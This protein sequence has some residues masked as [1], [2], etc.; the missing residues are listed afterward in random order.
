MLKIRGGIRVRLTLAITV[1]SLVLM[2]IVGLAIERT[3]GEKIFQDSRNQA[4]ALLESLS[5]PCAMEKATNSLERLD[6]SLAE[7]VRVGGGKLPILE[8][9]F[10]DHSGNL[11][12][13]SSQRHGLSVSPGLQVLQRAFIDSSIRSTRPTWTRFSG[14]DDLAV[15]QVSMPAVS[16]LRWGTLVAAFHL[17][18]VMEELRWTRLILGGTAIGLALMLVILLHLTLSWMV[19]SPIRNL[20]DAVENIQQGFLGARAAVHSA[21]EL[22]QLGVGFNAMAE[23]LQSYTESLEKKVE[24]RA[25]EVRRKNR[26]LSEANAKLETLAR[27]DDLT[28]LY[29]RRYVLEVLDFEIR[30]GERSTNRLLVAMVDV[31]HFKRVNDTHGH[32]GGDRVLQQIADIF[33]ANLR[34]TDIIGR[35]G[36]EEF[37]VIFLDTDTTAGGQVAEKLRRKVEEAVF[38]DAGGNLVADV[39]ISIGLDKFSVGGEDSGTLIAHAD[40]ALYAAKRSGRNRVVIW[41]P[42]LGRS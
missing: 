9:A 31:D 42:D 33:R 24:E 15:L 16:G 1:T 23:E 41:R 10:F 4:A 30:R 3:I 11:V 36:G 29:N 21:D 40:E 27:T 13:Y 17:E 5:L 6:D 34:S 2:S 26:E 12:A 35:Y 7:L 28:Q 39:T 19:I 38:L 22:G 32:Q 25:H 37:L 8:V 20:A 14:S 18:P